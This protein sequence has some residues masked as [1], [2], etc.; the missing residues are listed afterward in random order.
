MVRLKAKNLTLTTTVYDLQYA[1]AAA[2]V[3]QYPDDLQCSIDILSL[4]Y[5]RADLQINKRKTVAL[6]HPVQNEAPVEIVIGNDSLKY[7]ACF[8]YLGSIISSIGVI[9]E[10]IISR[11]QVASSA[12]EWLERKC[13]SIMTSACEQK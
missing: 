8:N 4:A 10:E 13:S 6:H 11:I 2:Q 3:S 5:K 7:V 1:D 12:S 9:Y